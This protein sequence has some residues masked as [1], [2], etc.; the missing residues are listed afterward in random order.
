MYKYLILLL[1]VIILSS[2]AAILH[3]T[4]DEVNFNSNPEGAEVWVNGELKGFTPL[5]NLKLKSDKDYKV[6]IKKSG[7]TTHI[8]SINSGVS[9]G[10]IVADVLLTGLLGVVVDAAT[11]SWYVLDETD[12]NVQLGASK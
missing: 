3:G 11:G 8:G 9:G 4:T 7:F 6:E 1:A 5:L 2:C 10:Y 12:I